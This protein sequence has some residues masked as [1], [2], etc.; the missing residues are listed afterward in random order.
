MKEANILCLIN[1]SKTFGTEARKLIKRRR[2]MYRF[3]GACS[4][5]SM[6]VVPSYSQAPAGRAPAT[7]WLLDSEGGT[8]PGYELPSLAF[9][10]SIERPITE[11]IELQ[12]GVSF[13]PT[14]TLSTNDGHHF[15]VSGE[16]LF[17]ITH[18]FAVTAALSRGYLWTS[19]YDL[20]GWS[21]SIGL[22]IREQ[23]F[24]SPG[25]F[26]LSFLIPTGCQW[27]A[28]CP[29]QSSRETGPKI[30]WERRLSSHWRFG[31]EFG[32]YRVLNQGNPLDPA[33]GRTGQ[34]TGDAH[35][36]SRF[37]FPGG[38]LEEAY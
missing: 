16:G 7:R 4:L 9:G 15:D 33:A 37:E 2:N 3:L 6:F 5:I 38:G 28:S 13:S 17:W 18:R 27:G 24:D 25:R 26:Y 30:N 1:K 34:V 14:K 35:I 11:R 22:A 32:V 29:I 10:V 12:G 36:I 8:D 20:Q 23:L 31:F 21:P 19:Q